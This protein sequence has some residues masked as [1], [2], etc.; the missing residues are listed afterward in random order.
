MRARNF[1]SLVFVLCLAAA[2]NHCLF[3]S[4]CSEK[5]L[6]TGAPAQHHHE[7]ESHPCGAPCNIEMQ[8][9]AI[10]IPQMEPIAIEVSEALSNIIVASRGDPFFFSLAFTS[11]ADYPPRDKQ[12]RPALLTDAANAPPAV[13]L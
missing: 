3:E 1:F 12:R 8:S 5:S 11:S 7:P 2:A 13:S 10:K 4:L 9:V 6:S